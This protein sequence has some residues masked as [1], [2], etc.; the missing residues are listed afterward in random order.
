VIATRNPLHFGVTEVAP[1]IL[2]FTD[3]ILRVAHEL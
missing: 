3:N 2:I 1:L